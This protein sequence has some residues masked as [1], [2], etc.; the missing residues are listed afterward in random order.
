MTN[1]AEINQSKNEAS[2][3]VA[4]DN[5][6]RLF[7]ADE[8][9]I[10]LTIYIPAEYRQSNGRLY[11][12]GVDKHHRFAPKKR[13]L[14]KE[15]DMGKLL[16]YS[17]YQY[18]PVKLHRAFNSYYDE[19]KLPKDI[20]A[21]FGAILLSIARYLP[22][23]AVD[24]SGESPK[25]E[26]L[27]LEERQRI[28]ANNE[29][30]PEQGSKLQQ[31]LLNHVATR[32]I[33]GVDLNLVQEFVTTPSDDIRI[34]IGKQLLRAAAEVAVEPVEQDYIDA[35]ESKLLPRQ[36]IRPE[37]A[38]LFDITQARAVPKKPA[39]FVLRHVVKDG[40]ALGRALNQLEDSLLGQYPD[41]LAA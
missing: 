26:G 33:E 38:R 19:P 3:A 31:E 17:C 24:V 30:R 41:L 28:W 6:D 16:R 22:E 5:S 15:P 8:L 27:S 10:P 40:Y 13:L 11:T 21:R 14:H 9:G 2:R 32:K 23:D 35:W 20:A 34:K 18:V 36:D 12:S 37:T 7:P 25:E 29:L 4:V 39:S 1:T